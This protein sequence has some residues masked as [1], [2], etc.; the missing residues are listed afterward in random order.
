MSIIGLN[1][2]T[3]ASNVAIRNTERHRI[4]YT[5][6]LRYTPVTDEELYRLAVYNGADNTANYIELSVQDVT[7]N[8]ETTVNVYSENMAGG[9]STTWTIKALTHPIRLFAGRTYSIAARCISGTFT[10]RTRASSDTYVH[11]PLLNLYRFAESFGEQSATTAQAMCVYGETQAISTIPQITSVEGTYLTPP[12]LYPGQTAV[13]LASSATNFSAS[14]NTVK[15]C[16]TNNYADANAVTQTI[17]SE[18]TSAVDFT[19]VQGKLPYGRNYLF[20]ADGSANKSNAVPI[21]LTPPSGYAYVNIT[22]A[23]AGGMIGVY[24]GLEAYTAESGTTMAKYDQISYQTTSTQGGTVNIDE[25]GSVKVVYPGSAPASDT[26]LARA[27][28]YTDYTWSQ[29]PGAED[30]VTINN[31]SGSGS[32]ITSIFNRRRRRH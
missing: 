23:A 29:V 3:G 18:S 5:A 15:I 31:L 30:T 12:N 22:A 16:P 11:G 21:I 20:L 6:G 26:F 7:S 8:F 19:V 25:F 17:T 14:G 1:D 32:T 28:D 9:S 24:S 4:N 13:T 27:F 2:V 10:I